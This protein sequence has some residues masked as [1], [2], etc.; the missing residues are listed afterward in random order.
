MTRMLIVSKG[1]CTQQSM[2]LQKFRKISNPMC[3]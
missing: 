3:S 1:E 2:R